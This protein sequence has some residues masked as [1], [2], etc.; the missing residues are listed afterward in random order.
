MSGIN[1]NLKFGQKQSEE[2]EDLRD[3]KIDEELSAVL[4]HFTN[5]DKNLSF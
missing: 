3:L 4:D 5:I 1:L 2:K